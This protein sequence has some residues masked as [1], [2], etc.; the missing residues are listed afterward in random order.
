M[1]DTLFGEQGRYMYSGK[2][3]EV[4]FSSIARFHGSKLGT[5]QEQ[6]I[7]ILAEVVVIDHILPTPDMG[8]ALFSLGTETRHFHPSQNHPVIHTAPILLHFTT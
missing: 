6:G 1:L 3:K 5:L 4:A 2:N 8:L 7:G